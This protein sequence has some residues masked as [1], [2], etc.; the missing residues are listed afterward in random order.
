MPIVD[1]IKLPKAFLGTTKTISVF[2]FGNQK[3][4]QRVYIQAG[5]HA[6]EHP[7]LLVAHELILKLKRL[8]EQDLI[9]GRVDI[10]PVA[11]PIGMAQ[12]LN[13][14]INGRYDFLERKNFNRGFNQKLIH[15]VLAEQEKKNK[16]ENE[17]ELYDYICNQLRNLKPRTHSEALKNILLGEA[18]GANIMLDLHCDGE[19]IPHIY[20]NRKNVDLARRVAANMAFNTLVLSDEHNNSDAFDDLFNYTVNHVE[21]FFSNKT[22]LYGAVT[23]ELRGRADVSEEFANQDSDG[24]ISF[25]GEI[26]LLK[27]Q[28]KNTE[29]I[30]THPEIP[31]HTIQEVFSSSAGIIVHCKNLGDT[32]L[33]G[34]TIAK[35]IDP[36]SDCSD[37]VEIV[38]S[39]KKGRIFSRH[40]SKLAFPGMEIAK[41][42]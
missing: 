26:G 19:S 42:A 24:I 30:K 40:I 34:E 28:S 32:V 1:T 39:E 2:R 31:L 4:A 20:S 13:G 7:G 37:P 23:I 3:S 6:G 17:P 35:I 12:F 15:Q 25:L 21:S 9:Q 41:I 18:L 5:L 11:N 22:S 14:E 38:K 33:A 27:K 8:E 36:L 29:D 10:V 16:F